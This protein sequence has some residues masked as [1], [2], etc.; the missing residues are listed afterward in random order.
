MTIHTALAALN[1]RL[2]KLDG[3]LRILEWAVMEAK[4]G[5]DT[6]DGL[7]GE[8]FDAIQELRGLVHQA[9]ELVRSGHQANADR[10]DLAGVYQALAGCQEH[11]N[12]ATKLFYTRLSSPAVWE[13]LNWLAKGR[14]SD[15]APWVAGVRDA[16]RGLADALLTGEDGSVYQAL[17]AGWQEIGDHA[18]WTRRIPGSPDTGSLSAS[19][20][21]LNE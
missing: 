14:R 5:T 7:A 13:S 15:W 6:G 8:L 18:G 16:Q 20:A 1:S 4:P 17:L 9:G 11:A 3:E 21:R 12:R 19:A 10:S 2:E